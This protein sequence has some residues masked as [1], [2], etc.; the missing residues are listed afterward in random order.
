MLPL[1]VMKARQTAQFTFNSVEHMCAVAVAFDEFWGRIH[2][3]V[4]LASVGLISATIFLFF[5]HG[6]EV[7]LKYREHRKKLN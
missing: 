1:A 2:L 5:I 6:V 4:E 7:T 3:L